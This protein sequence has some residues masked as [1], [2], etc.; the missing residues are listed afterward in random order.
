MN[1]KGKSYQLLLPPSSYLPE[2]T[3]VLQTAYRQLFLASLEV[4]RRANG[5]VMISFTGNERWN[6]DANGFRF[7]LLLASRDPGGDIRHKQASDES[8]R[9]RLPAGDLITSTS[10]S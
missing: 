5:R 10:S 2:F 7:S 1:T 4:L 9:T 3:G 8:S 6:R